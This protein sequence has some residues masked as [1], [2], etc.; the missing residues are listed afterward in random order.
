MERLLAVVGACYTLY[1]L[2]RLARVGLRL[3]E[4]NE[5]LRR[6][7]NQANKQAS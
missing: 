7:Y 3:V 1:T 4:E 2:G 6:K 5:E